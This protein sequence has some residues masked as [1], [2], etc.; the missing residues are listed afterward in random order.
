ML[1]TS[2]CNSACLKALESWPTFDFDDFHFLDF[3]LRQATTSTTARRGTHCS[4]SPRAV[5]NELSDLR[6]FLINSR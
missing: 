6:N 1:L 3:E 4:E 2:L 5:T